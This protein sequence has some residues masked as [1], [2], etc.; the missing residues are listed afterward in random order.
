[1]VRRGVCARVRARTAA[2]AASVAATAAF[3]LRGGMLVI[4][5]DAYVLY[6]SLQ[7]LK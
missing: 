3:C 6:V 2:A 1:M 7:C 4:V 5:L